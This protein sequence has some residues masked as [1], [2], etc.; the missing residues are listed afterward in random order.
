MYLRLRTSDVWE[1]RGNFG[2]GPL[3]KALS[4]VC[5]PDDILIVGSYWVSED[6]LLQLAAN[7]IRLPEGYEKPFSETFDL[8]KSEYPGGRFY[9]FNPKETVLD[10]LAA[11]SVVSR[12]GVEK[13]IFFDH[14]LVYREGRPLIPLV[15]FHDAFSGE[16]RDASTGGTL[17]LSGHYSDQTINAFAERLG[18]TAELV[19]NPDLRVQ[20]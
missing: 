17:Y 9:V 5:A 11:L 13:D 14:L 15:Y 4:L 20:G 16:T 10:R 6:V 12:G 19:D 8:N 2:P 3:F 1:I 18:A 7:E